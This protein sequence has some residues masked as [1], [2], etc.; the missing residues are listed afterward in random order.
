M[1]FIVAAVCFELYDRSGDGR[2]RLADFEAV[3]RATCTDDV[4]LERVV[5][6]R[7]SAL[8]Q[9]H[10]L[11]V[12]GTINFEE[13]KGLIKREPLLVKVF[14]LP[15]VPVLKSAR[16]APVPSPTCLPTPMAMEPGDDVGLETELHPHFPSYGCAYNHTSI[17]DTPYIVHHTPY[18]RI[19]PYPIP[20]HTTPHTP[21]TV[22]HTPYSG[23]SIQRTLIAHTTTSPIPVVSAVLHQLVP[24][25]D[26]TT[27]PLDSPHGYLC[28]L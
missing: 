8:S 19:Q 15:G 27:P 11:A 13:F 4:A 16:E 17:T 6:A 14:L 3:L 5:A 20:P 2:I 12:D 26:T 18:T 24:H 22:P 28:P 9:R 23:H 7:L 25:H 10:D 1:P 21:Y